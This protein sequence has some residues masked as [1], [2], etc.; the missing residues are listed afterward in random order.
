M[1][2]FTAYSILASLWLNGLWLWHSVFHYPSK[3]LIQHWH[4]TRFGTRTCRV[5]HEQWHTYHTSS[6]KTLLLTAKTMLIVAI[7]SSSII[8]GFALLF[9]PL[10][11]LPVF[12]SKMLV[13]TTKKTTEFGL[14]YVFGILE[15]FMILFA[16]MNIP[17]LVF[18]R[19]FAHS[20]GLQR[21]N[22]S[23]FQLLNHPRLRC[24]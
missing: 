19:G 22:F 5:K 2:D 17:S 6:Q 9:W 8:V 18:L 12:T 3:S 23:I 13:L 10:Y 11:M 21:T 14:L 4:H 1:W 24:L 7:I 20:F 16:T 15:L